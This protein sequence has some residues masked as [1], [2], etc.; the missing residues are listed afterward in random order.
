MGADG[1]GAA[2]VRITDIV[3]DKCGKFMSIRSG[4]Y[5]E[6]LSCTGYPDC[7][8]AKPIPLGVPCPKCGGDIIEIKSKKKGGKAFYGCS[9]YSNESV[10]CDFKLWQKPIPEPCPDCKAPFLTMG[11]TKAK[12]FIQCANKECGYRRDVVHEEPA[13]EPVAASAE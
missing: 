1:L 6:F 12:P 9:N 4:R 13:P 11:G 5:G 10:K 8:N 3:C 2:P 7:K